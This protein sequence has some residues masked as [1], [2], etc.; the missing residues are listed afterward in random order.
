MGDALYEALLPNMPERGVPRLCAGRRHGDLL[1]YLVRRLLENGANSSFVSVAADPTVP[2]EAHFRSA[3][4][5]AIRNAE[6][7]RV[8][9][10]S[11][12]AG[13]LRPLRGAIR[14]G[15]EFGDSRRARRAAR[16]RARRRA[17]EPA[18]A[19]PLVD[20]IAIPGRKRE[21]H[22]PIDG[23]VA[24]HR[25]AKATRRSSTA[26]MT[27]AAAGFAAWDATPVEDARPRR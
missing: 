24:R 26:A 2:V 10:D 20:G 27:A 15:V 6:P 9:R 12:A 23:T 19:T 22:S 7:A 13:S 1:A 3:R 25:A 16:R 4:Q 18:E 11:A 14:S 17:R 8:T 21:S 5:A